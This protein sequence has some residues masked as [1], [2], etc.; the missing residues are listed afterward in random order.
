MFCKKMSLLVAAASLCSGGA[1]AAQ[2]VPGTSEVCNGN[3]QNP[4]ILS[5]ISMAANGKANAPNIG[6]KYQVALDCAGATGGLAIF[7]ISFGP[8]PSPMTSPFGEILVNFGA[9]TGLT[10]I[11]PREAGKL[12]AWPR[13]P[14]RVPN[15]PSTVG[16]E[17]TIQG[18]C[19]SRP[20]GFLS[21]CLAEMI[22]DC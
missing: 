21:N 19:S 6:Q 22:G 9:G 11:I 10:F 4:V 7:R 15:I 14:C 8:E 13:S 5:N 18:L 12:S 17:F 16:M 3:N 2:G 20:R 1:W